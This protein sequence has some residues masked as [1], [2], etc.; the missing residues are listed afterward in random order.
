MVECVYVDPYAPIEY[1]R[2]DI[3]PSSIKS[4]K[5]FDAKS[6]KDSFYFTGVLTYRDPK[7]NM[8][9]PPFF[10]VE[11]DSYGVQKGGG[12]AK[13]NKAGDAALGGGV[14]GMIPLGGGFP[15]MAGMP[16]QQPQYGQPQQ[17]G[18]QGQAG[19]DGEG[20]DKL[21]IAIQLSEKPAEK[22]WTPR[23]RAI[24]EFIDTTIRRIICHVLCRQVN[25]VNQVCPNVVI[26]AREKFE[27]KF[28]LNGQQPNQEQMAYFQEALKDA[29]YGKISRK[30]YRKK[31][32]TTKQGA[33]FNPLDGSSQYD[34]TKFPTLYAGI[35]SFV[36]KITKA[37]KITKTVYLQWVADV[38]EDD[39]PKLTHAE[40]LAKGSQHVQV[41]V[42]YD[43]IY[44]GASIA[45]QPKAA[46]I[47]FMR[48]TQGGG[49]HKGRMIRAPDGVKRDQRLI[50]RSNIEPAGGS[51]EQ[52]SGGIEPVNPL[53]SGVLREFNPTMLGSVPGI[54]QQFQGGTQMTQFGQGMPQAPGGY[55]PQ[56]T[57]NYGAPIQQFQVPPQMQQQQ[58][59]QPQ[60]QFQQ[61]IPQF[62]M[63][64]QPVP[65]QG[66]GS[67]VPMLQSGGFQ[68]QPQQQIQ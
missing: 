14:P 66:D 48:A 61:P 54:G 1:D 32:D 9:K 57:A 45:S 16:G 59:G 39:W 31:K 62:Q 38:A 6:G 19:P 34:E 60:Q 36:D 53:N 22:D 12:Q 52:H 26:A 24:I 2:Y 18:Q 67:G 47:A 41:G 29:L 20:K 11:G 65:Q 5:F 15:Q 50:T 58:Y 40:A 23:E 7:D 63:P 27:Q 10:L 46:E 51:V 43:D 35:P 30:V 21:Q 3:N 17:Q 25:I 55:V 4:K 64:Q 13:D 56:A 33:A 44:F 42:R 68:Q 8:P 49:L 37:E 28:Q